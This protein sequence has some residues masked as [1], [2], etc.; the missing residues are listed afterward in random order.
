MTEPN[1][2]NQSSSMKP[3][4]SI[5][6]FA[7]NMWFINKQVASEHLLASV[8]RVIIHK[9]HC[10]YL[11]FPFNYYLIIYEATSVSDF[12]ACPKSSNRSRLATVSG[13]SCVS[14]LFVRLY[15]R[16]NQ[17]CQH[18]NMYFMRK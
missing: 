9:L 6:R 15:N 10:K 8:Q 1:Y 5:S 13:H 4:S 7:P 12:Q 14:K 2:L 17:A 11:L 16:C 3:T 18:G